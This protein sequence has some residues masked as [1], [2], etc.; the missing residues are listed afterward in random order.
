[1]TRASAD[2]SLAQ[3]RCF[4]AVVSAGSFAEAG[5]RLGMATSAVSRTIARLEAARGVKLLHRSTHA[6]SLT[7]DGE[8][9]IDVARE[10][11]AGVDRVEAALGDMA[12]GGA[13]GRVRIAAPVAFARHCLVPL[14]P[15]FV[16]A[17]PDIRLDLRASSAMA[18]LA[19][20]GIDLA[21][22][23]GSLAGM[24]GHVQQPWLSF[25]WVA[26]ATP[27]YLAG[28]GRPARP[29]E[30]HGHDLIGFRNP[31]TG[32]VAA[33]RFR[34]DEADGSARPLPEPRIVFDD[35]GAAWGAALAGLGVAWAPYWLAADA[36]RSGE[37]V[38]VLGEWRGEETQLSIVRRDRR[39]LPKRVEAVIQFLKRHAARIAPPGP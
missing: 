18:D 9:L 11:M 13:A 14:L 36:L 22:R 27:G 8:L 39:L 25:P 3:L 33:W 7:K 28:R 2:L 17:H 23:S 24:P 31:R 10:A 5:R 12:A 29:D 26:C 21:L 37:A 1:M 16:R 35:G 38:E 4:V 34:A 6:L 20:A 15:D 19:D 32:R 30:L